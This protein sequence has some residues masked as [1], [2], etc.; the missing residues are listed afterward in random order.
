VTQ[1]EHIETCMTYR[2]PYAENGP[3]QHI[4]WLC[5]LQLST[6]ESSNG[7]CMILE[8]VFIYITET[9]YGAIERHFQHRLLED[10]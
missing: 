7:E 8:G 3:M 6:F 2:I 9:L 1:V 5:S 10:W 4:K